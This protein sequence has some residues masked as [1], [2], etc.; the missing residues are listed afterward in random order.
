MWHS[1]IIVFA[2][3]LRIVRKTVHAIS[4]D[5]MIVCKEIQ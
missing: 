1:I 5:Q 4:E 2:D 3:L